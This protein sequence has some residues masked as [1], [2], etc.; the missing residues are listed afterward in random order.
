MFK[1]LHFIKANPDVLERY[2]TICINKTEFAS[3]DYGG[4]GLS[5]NMKGNEGL[6]LKSSSG[7]LGICYPV[8]S[9]C[10]LYF[11]ILHDSLEIKKPVEKEGKFS[12][13]VPRWDP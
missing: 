10:V 13:S 4:G 5:G 11:S 8:L 6:L 3:K 12:Y 1:I 9:E 7:Y 2:T